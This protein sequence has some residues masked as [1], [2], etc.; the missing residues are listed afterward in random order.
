MG[1]LFSGSN[2]KARMDWTGSNNTD[3]DCRYH[4]PFVCNN[5]GN[6]YSVANGKL[7]TICNPAVSSWENCKQGQIIHIVGMAHISSVSAD[8]AANV[9]KEIQVWVKMIKFDLKCQ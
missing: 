6:S 7:A 4:H 2:H 1:Q 8:L 9:V 3:W 5:I